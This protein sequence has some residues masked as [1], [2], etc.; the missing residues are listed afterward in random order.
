MY[1]VFSK[2]LLLPWLRFPGGSIIM[3][4]HYPA[5]PSRALFL[6]A[7]CS[8]APYPPPTHYPDSMDIGIANHPFPSPT[9]MCLVFGFLA[10]S[11]PQRC[12]PAFFP[13]LYPAIIALFGGTS[14]FL[15]WI[16]LGAFCSRS[17]GV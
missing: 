6:T 1:K 11:H 4:A 10:L 17:S 13:F 5:S 15:F 3:R 7:I 12:P 2:S 16:I 9:C 8:P 14:L